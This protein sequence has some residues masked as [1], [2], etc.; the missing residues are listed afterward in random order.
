MLELTGLQWQFG[1]F[2]TVQAA[3]TGPHQR[4][5]RAD[6]RTSMVAH[7]KLARPVPAPSR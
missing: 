6:T 5:G 7:W 4:E 2:P 3:V 1:I